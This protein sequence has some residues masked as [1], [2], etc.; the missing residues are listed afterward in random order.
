MIA[1]LSV[2]CK[3]LD[4][5]VDSGGEEKKDE[6]LRVSS[7]ARLTAIIGLEAATFPKYFELLFH[8][9]DLTDNSIS[10][11]MHRASIARRPLCARRQS[12]IEA[13]WDV[14]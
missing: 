7:S 8:A 1:Q 11:Q 10:W 4:K 9:V 13:T 3:S 12:T 2:L 6:E 14:P 5:G